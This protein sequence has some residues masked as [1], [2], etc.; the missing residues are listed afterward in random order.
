M[1]GLARR[2]HRARAL[3][4][5]PRRRLRRR[6]E[7]RAARRRRPLQDPRGRAHPRLERL[8]RGVR[9]GR[10][11][12][13]ARVQLPALRGHPTL[14][15]AR[16]DRQGPSC[17]RRRPVGAGLREERPRRRALGL[18]D[19]GRL[20]L[21]AT[22]QR[23][24]AARRPLRPLRRP[25]ARGR[26]LGHP[27]RQRRHRYVPRAQGHR[28]GG[29]PPPRARAGGHLA[30]ERDGSP[31]R[32]PH[33]RPAR[34]A[35]RHR[36]RLRV[37]LGRRR[38][39][40]R[41]HRL[42]QDRGLPRGHRARALARRLG[43]RAR[44]RDLPHGPDRR[45]LPLPLR[46]RRRHPALAPLGRRA[47]RPVGPRP[48][49]PGPRRGR[50]PLGALRAPR[51][52]RPRDHRRGARGELQAGHARTPGEGSPGRASACPSAPE[53]P[54]SPRSASST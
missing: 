35:L 41:R 32:A 9:R 15:C 16:P 12:D 52:P 7:Q 31:T 42:W 2:L 44:P 3:L 20:L 21:R 30:L 14:P 48:L 10:P 39:R 53:A 19:G 29:A 47:L 45:P 11:L 8:R 37:R 36:R 54:P 23:Q 51:R 49:G 43:P 33:G 46:R 38:G 24:Q 26:A 50:R 25:H 27:P 4:P 1:L 40:R 28:L 5:P 34:G 22:R 13:R 6:P 17:E 18:S